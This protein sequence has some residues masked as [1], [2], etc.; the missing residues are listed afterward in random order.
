MIVNC[1]I[2]F[3]LTFEKAIFYHP[4]IGGNDDIRFSIQA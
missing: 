3:K 4:V 1:T 2:K